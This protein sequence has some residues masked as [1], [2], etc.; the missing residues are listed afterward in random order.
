MKILIIFILC[1]FLFSNTN[2]QE[3]EIIF[4]SS[5]RTGN[6]NI[7]QM[8]SDGKNVKQQTF[9]KTEKWSPHQLNKNEI[10]LC[11]IRTF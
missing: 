1:F 3:K 7:F 9:G 2:L 6:L 5:N 4:F 8:D 11:K 10:D